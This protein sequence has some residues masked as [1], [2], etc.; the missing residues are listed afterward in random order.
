MK[1]HSAQTMQTICFML[2]T[3]FS[4]LRVL[5]TCQAECVCMTSPPTRSLM[6]VS[7]QKQHTNVRAF[8]YLKRTLWVT[9][10]DGETGKNWTL[11]ALCLF[12]YDA[13]MYSNCIALINLSREYL[14]LPSPLSL[15]SQSVTVAVARGTPSTPLN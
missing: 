8:C 9:S 12:P 10:W 11:Q 2:N 7:G 4:H 1:V 14:S 3:F 13:A 15:S 6:G 5:N